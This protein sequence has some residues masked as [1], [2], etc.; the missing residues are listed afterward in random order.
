MIFFLQLNSDKTKESASSTRP[1]VYLKHITWNSAMEWNYTLPDIHIAWS[2]VER[3]GLGPF[4]GARPPQL[5]A[6]L[7]VVGVSWFL[8]T[9]ASRENLGGGSKY[10]L[11]SPPLTWGNDPIWLISFRWAVQP[12][13]NFP[14]EFLGIKSEK[15]FAWCH[16]SGKLRTTCRVR[17]AEVLGL[18]ENAGKSWESLL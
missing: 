3:W 2:S 11:F 10:F 7:V 9:Q 13:R 5:A 12:P 18:E 15:V 4:W 16:G 6:M 1:W 14:T 8:S 17:G